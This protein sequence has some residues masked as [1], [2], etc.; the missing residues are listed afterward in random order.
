VYFH[1]FP[2]AVGAAYHFEILGT[3]G[4]ILWKEGGAWRQPL[5][6]PD[7]AQYS[8]EWQPLP[9]P[10][11][12]GEPGVPERGLPEGGPQRVRLHPAPPAADLPF[13]V[14]PDEYAYVDEYVH[15]LDEDRDPPCSGEAARHALEILVGL[16]E[17]A[18]YGVRVTLPQARRDHPLLRWRRGAGL[19]DPEPRPREYRDWLAAED[20]RI[21]RG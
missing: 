9:P 16:F 4:R 11:L 19:P 8:G 7:P 2:R 20:E 15:A 6:Y 1:R 13:V 21:S 5:F 3:E 10:G 14:A 18:A 17:A 12:I